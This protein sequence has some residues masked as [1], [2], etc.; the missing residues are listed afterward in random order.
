MGGRHRGGG[1]TAWR[2][3]ARILIAAAAD[4]RSLAITVS[5]PLM[6]SIWKAASDPSPTDCPAPRAIEY[7]SAINVDSDLFEVGALVGAEHGGQQ[8]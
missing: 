3:S 6:V 7:C 4:R 2:W 8:R 1:N 5:L